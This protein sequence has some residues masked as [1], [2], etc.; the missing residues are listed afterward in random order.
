M[1]DRH[2]NTEI[3]LRNDIERDGVKIYDCD[4]DLSDLQAM[5]GVLPRFYGLAM[6]EDYLK[7]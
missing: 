1:L 6:A 5:G 4:E 7:I 3:V 2:K